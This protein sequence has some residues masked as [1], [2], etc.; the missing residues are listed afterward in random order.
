MYWNSLLYCGR[1]MLGLTS[2]EGITYAVTQITQSGSF[3]GLMK[4]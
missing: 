4:R 2:A 3:I 1:G